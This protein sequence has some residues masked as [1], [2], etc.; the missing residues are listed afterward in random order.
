[1]K[2]AFEQWYNDLESFANYL[3]VLAHLGKGESDSTGEQSVHPRFLEEF[4]K[5][6]LIDDPVKRR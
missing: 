1:M 4:D 6:S 5:A 3:A 2:D